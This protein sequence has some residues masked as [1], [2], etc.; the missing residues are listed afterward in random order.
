MAFEDRDKWTRGSWKIAFDKEQN[1]PAFTAMLGTEVLGCAGVVIPWSGFGI[2]WVT[3][4]E[5]I[6]NHK[7]WMNRM[8]RRIL[9]DVIRAHDLVRVESVVLADNYRNQQW[10]NGLKF[11]REN[12]C[13]RKYAPDQRDVIR[14]ERVQ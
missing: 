9:E 11:T 10:I 3:L 1:G 5:K 13:A 2:A 7:I 8:I 4:N 12:G 14:Y 6:L